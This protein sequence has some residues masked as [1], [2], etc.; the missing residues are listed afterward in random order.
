MNMK[1]IFDQNSQYIHVL[2]IPDSTMTQPYSKPCQTSKM[3]LF[4]KIYNSLKHFWAFPIFFLKKL[5]LPVFYPYS[6]LTR[7]VHWSMTS[8]PQKHQPHLFLAKSP[9][10]SANCP[11]P[12]FLGNPPYI[13]VSR[14]PPP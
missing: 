11:S 3:E 5:V 7:S 13:L 14:E 6:P 12:P 4:A 2:H 9:L 10:K 8:P 1:T